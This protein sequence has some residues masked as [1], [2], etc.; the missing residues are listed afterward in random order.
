MDNVEAYINAH[1]LQYRDASDIIEEF[2]SDMAKMKG[3]CIDIGCGPGN[4]TKEL[5]LRNLPQETEVIGVDIS[6]SMLDYAN[7]KYR[8][9]KCLSFKYLDIETPELPN[10]ELNQYD[11][12]LSFYCLHWCQNSWLAFENIYKLLRPGGKALLMFLGYND[13]FDAYV[14]LHENPRYQPYMKDA[15]KYIPYFHRCDDSRAVLRK[16]LADVGFHILHCSRRDKSFV[17]QNMQILKSHTLAVNPFISRVPDNLKQEFEDVTLRE[18]VSQKIL[19]ANKNSGGQEEYSILDRYSL[20][21][22]F[23]EKPLISY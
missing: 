1:K 11:N 20:L 19:F 8:E 14:R 18:V 17:Y 3:R 6:R 12:A 13:G 15:Y 16:I 22:A 4:V 5:I 7:W 10:E 2:S 9:E 21:V 23:V